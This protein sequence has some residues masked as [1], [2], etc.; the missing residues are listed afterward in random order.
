MQE[1]PKVRVT[2]L[3]R[4][5]REGKRVVVATAYDAITARW[6]E[7]GGVDVILVGDSLGNTALG[8]RDPIPM[9]LD[10]MLHH[11]AAVARGASRPLLVGDMP[12][13]TYKISPEQAMTSAWRFVQEGR[14]EG[15][16]LEGGEEIA[17]TVERLVQAGIPVMG[18]VGLLPQSVH[19]HGGYRRQG[20]DAASAERLLVD[21]RALEQAGAFAIVLEMIAPDL[22]R[23]VTEALSIPTIGIGAGPACDGQVLV[24]ADLLGMIPGAAP[25]FAKAYADLWQAATEAIGQY[26]EETRH[27]TFPARE[28]EP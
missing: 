25:G 4:M 1:Q 26:A 16:K 9:T 18:H 11:C 12:F 20:V 2:T 3:A 5:K 24:L 14:M 8:H 22:A 13:M 10:A 15:V 19:Q 27:G 21:A 28:D 17:P 23:R 7:A 6:V